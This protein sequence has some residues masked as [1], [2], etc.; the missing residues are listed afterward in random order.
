MK[1][2]FKSKAFPAAA[3]SVACIGVLAIS[4]FIGR[5]ERTDFQPEE[6]APETAIREWTET[7]ATGKQPADSSN[8]GTSGAYAASQPPDSEEDLTAYPKTV[9][10]N[11]GL[12]TIDFTPEA[13][14]L[15]PEPPE[16]PVTKEDTGDPEQPPAYAPE[17]L[18][19]APTDFPAQPDTPAAGSGNG[20][21]A[22][23]DPVFGWV[24]PGSVSQT[25]M[26]S[27]GDPDKMVGNMGN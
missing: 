23:Y 7:P 24:V 2:I 3:L 11:D 18:E 14:R 1:N 13:E 5:E 9:E 17:E 4:L 26:D 19:P 8:G 22:I 20:N 15:Q 10:E 25:A 21:G 16:A 12:V 6:P 27:A